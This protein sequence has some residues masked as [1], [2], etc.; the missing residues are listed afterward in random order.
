MMTEVSEIITAQIVQ[1]T[2]D[3]RSTLR[4][5]SKSLAPMKWA[6]CTEKPIFAAEARP[7]ISQ[8]EVST[9]PMAAEA[10][11]PR[12]PTIEASMKNITVAEICARIEGILRLTMSQSF[13]L[14]VIVR[15][16]RI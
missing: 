6:T 15:P 12:C 3:C 5:A 2:S 16:S 10:F 9:I 7:P 13:S 14:C 1:Q 4:A 11:A 8:P